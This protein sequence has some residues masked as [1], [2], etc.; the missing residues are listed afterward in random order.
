M[1]E[2]EEFYERNVLAEQTGGEKQILDL[3]GRENFW[4]AMEFKYRDTAFITL[5]NLDDEHERNVQAAQKREN[6]R[7]VLGDATDLSQYGDNSFDVVFSNS[8][9]EH[10]GNFEA[11]KRMAKEMLRVGK[12]CYLQTPNYY[13]FMEPHFLIPF[14]QFLPLKLRMFLLQ[15]IKINGEKKSPKEAES[16]RL[17]TRKELQSLFPSSEIRREKMGPF[18]KSFYLFV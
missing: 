15:H 6:M 17:M 4:D 12:H 13:F 2:F 11:Q 1:Q 8:V 10:V 5:L 9:I 7:C 18:T 14:F 3:G 16:I